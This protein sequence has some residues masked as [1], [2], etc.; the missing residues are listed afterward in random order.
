MDVLSYVIVPSNEYSN[1]L[2]LKLISEPYISILV[3]LVYAKAE[4]DISKE[5]E[6]ISSVLIFVL[7]DV[8]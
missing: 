6:L 8:L 1:D 7:Y 3:I 4:F 5:D 2:L